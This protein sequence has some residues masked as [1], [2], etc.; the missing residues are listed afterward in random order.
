MN[1]VMPRLV[2]VGLIFAGVTF[3]SNS[4]VSHRSGTQWGY[5]LMG[6][7]CLLLRTAFAFMVWWRDSPGPKGGFRHP[8]E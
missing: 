5:A 6:M 7:T 2:R 8:M 4:D 3:G 1:L